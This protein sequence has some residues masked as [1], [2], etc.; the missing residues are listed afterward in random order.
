MVFGVPIGS[1]RDVTFSW[2]AST[3]GVE[4]SNNEKIVISANS[5]E[6]YVCRAQGFVGKRDIRR[7][8]GFIIITVIGIILYSIVVLF[9]LY[10]YAT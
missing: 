5:D 7:T 4:V 9:L 1:M 6:E 10:L 2:R 8:R 3:S